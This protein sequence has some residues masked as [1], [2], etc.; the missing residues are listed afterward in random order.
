M[1][2]GMAYRADLSPLSGKTDNL[3]GYGNLLIL[4]Y[5]TEKQLSAYWISGQY[6]QLVGQMLSDPL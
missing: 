5:F 4:R 6:S 3:K 2:L 1:L